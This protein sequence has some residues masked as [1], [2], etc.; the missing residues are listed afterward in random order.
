MGYPAGSPTGDAD[1]GEENDGYPISG[2]PID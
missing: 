2:D 1:V